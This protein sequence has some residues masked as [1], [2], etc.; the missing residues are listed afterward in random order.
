MSLLAP[1]LNGFVVCYSELF[2]ALVNAPLHNE[3]ISIVHPIFLLC[4]LHVLHFLCV[5]YTVQLLSKSKTLT[6]INMTQSSVKQLY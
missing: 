3:V 4:N 5:L 6:D 1:Q 2:E